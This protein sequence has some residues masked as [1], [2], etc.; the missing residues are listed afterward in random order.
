[1]AEDGPPSPTLSHYSTASSV[2]TSD[3][4]MSLSD[5]SQWER[6]ESKASLAEGWSSNDESDWEQEHR[7]DA[8][9]RESN[10]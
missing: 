6:L 1:M 5:E 10:R 2:P 4:E 7:L 8:E 3:S 9:M